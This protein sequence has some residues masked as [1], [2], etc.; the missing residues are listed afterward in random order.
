MFTS[1]SL[2]FSLSHPVCDDSAG[3][4]GRSMTHMSSARVSS[5]NHHYGEK[6][7]QNI[8]M[9]PTVL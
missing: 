9:M 4:A 7:I 6:N 2:S 1:L 8:I 5:D 3:D